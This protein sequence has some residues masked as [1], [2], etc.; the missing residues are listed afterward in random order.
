[1]T[2][3][4]FTLMLDGDVE[5]HIDGLY[6]AG[7]DDALLGETNGIA[8]AAFD[9]DAPSLLE[10]IVDAIGQVH[11]VPGIEVIR[12]EPEDYLTAAEIA[13][14][15]GKSR[16]AIRLLAAGKRGSGN[17]PRPALRM[18][19]RSPLWR[20]SEILAWTSS[21]PDRQADAAAIGLLNAQ[22]EVERV[23]RTIPERQLAI[24]QALQS[25][26]A[27]AGELSQVLPRLDVD[28]LMRSL[29]DALE[30]VRA[31]TTDRPA[32]RS[33]EGAPDATVATSRTDR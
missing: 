17:F 19:N 16:E 6:E 11:S 1:M 24:L 15:T 18:R 5:S 2:E 9:R 14:H 29:E 27:S 4:N 26:P 33:L 32:H 7:L 12:V 13:S 10:A 8:Y 21:D 22:L 25:A 28:G 23:S 3:H 30:K 31:A 20:W